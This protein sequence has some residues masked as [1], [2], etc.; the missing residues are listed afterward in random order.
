MLQRGAV[1]SNGI[2]LFHTEIVWLLREVL[3]GFFAQN[4]ALP[5]K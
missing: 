2:S 4:P 3:T 5:E 1:L